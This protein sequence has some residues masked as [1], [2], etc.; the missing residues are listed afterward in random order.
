LGTPYRERF[1]A[2]RNVVE[3]SGKW[4]LSSAPNRVSG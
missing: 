2:E 1:I 4:L 3:G